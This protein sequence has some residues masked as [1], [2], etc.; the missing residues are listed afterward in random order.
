M[1]VGNEQGAQV[2]AGGV[3]VQGGIIGV[4][5]RSSHKSVLVAGV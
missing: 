3:I 5:H 2:H 4:F 1:D